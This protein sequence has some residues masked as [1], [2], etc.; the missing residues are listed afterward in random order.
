MAFWDLNCRLNIGSVC[1]RPKNNR[2]DSI[3]AEV[4]TAIQIS[5]SIIDLLM[6]RMVMKKIMWIDYKQNQNQILSTNST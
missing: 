6:V 2:S 5:N 1:P 3:T 4:F